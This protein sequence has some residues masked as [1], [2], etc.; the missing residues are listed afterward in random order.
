[1]VASVRQVVAEQAT[2][3]GTLTFF[4]RN[5]RP[6]LEQAKIA[7]KNELDYIEKRLTNLQQMNVPEADK[8]GFSRR[9][10]LNS[11]GGWAATLGGRGG[12][13]VAKF[14]EEKMVPD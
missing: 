2:S 14:S 4:Q 8:L 5:I 7:P 12:V 10:L 6:F 11:A 13:G 1:M 9:M 3:K